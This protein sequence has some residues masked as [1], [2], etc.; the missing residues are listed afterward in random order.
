MKRISKRLCKI[1]TFTIA[2]T[3][4]CSIPAC[5]SENNT[6]LENNIIFAE[7]TNGEIQEYS[8]KSII[9]MTEVQAVELGTKIQ[10]IVQNCEMVYVSGDIDIATLADICGISLKVYS[11][12]NNQQDN[13]TIGVAIV[14]AN[15]D[16]QLN[17]VTIL[18]ENLASIIN[19]RTNNLIYDGIE[20]ALGIDFSSNLKESGY[21]PRYPSSFDHYSHKSAVVY[22][23]EGNNIGSMYFTAY[24]CKK[25][26]W[27]SGYMFDTV[28]RATFAPKT[29][30]RCSKMYVTLG[31]TSSGYPSHKIIDQTGIESNGSSKTHAL[32]LSATADGAGAS[33]STSWTYTVDTQ[34]VTN[35][36]ADANSKSWTF[37]PVNAGNGDAWV[38]EPGIRS[39]SSSRT[40]CYTRITLKCPFRN[41]LGIEQKQNQ[42]DYNIYF[43]Y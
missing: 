10:E 41:I 19:K 15:G 28:C 16:I 2:I 9:V 39:V 6:G 25:G 36:F 33:A 22:D 24:F 5:S 1:I 13:P 43:N 18:A 40:N 3:L 31:H 34:N 21:A 42:L 29:G 12:N 23:D 37:S 11:E 30:Y 35:S 14:C 38:E 17:E 4:I 20:T 7:I 26:A 27:T 32:E 8:D